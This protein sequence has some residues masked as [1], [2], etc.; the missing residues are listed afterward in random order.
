MV[1]Y[2]VGKWEG[3]VLRSGATSRVAESGETPSMVAQAGRMPVAVTNGVQTG[4]DGDRASKLLRPPR[5]STGTGGR[6]N[7]AQLQSIR[8]GAVPV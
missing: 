3:R 6:R 2:P 5:E 8:G 4:Q 1:P 7:V